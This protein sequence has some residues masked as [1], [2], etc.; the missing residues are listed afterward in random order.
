MYI[1]KLTSDQ[2]SS[3]S[4]ISPEKDEGPVLLDIVVL[5]CD[6]FESKGMVSTSEQ[7]AT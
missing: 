1:Y 6:V 3:V 2:S 4:N 7:T 5:G